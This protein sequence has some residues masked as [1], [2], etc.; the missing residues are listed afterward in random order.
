MNIMIKPARYFCVFFLDNVEI[1][2][3]FYG[4]CC[5]YGLYWLKF[6]LF[7]AFAVMRYWIQ[8]STT[9]NLNMWTSSLYVVNMYHAHKF[10][11]V[12]IYLFIINA[13]ILYNL[14]LT[15]NA[16]IIR[17]DAWGFSLTSSHSNKTFFLFFCLNLVY[18]MSRGKKAYDYSTISF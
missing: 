18:Y 1:C 9:T 12:F 14:C 2:S 11:F 15:F 16:W 4:C 7:I 17:C 3:E 6:Y 5:F 10:F 13:P 8:I